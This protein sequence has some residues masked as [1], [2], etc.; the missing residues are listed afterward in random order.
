[1]VTGLR[2]IPS[3]MKRE[4]RGLE[5]LGSHVLAA[6]KGPF[7]AELPK[8]QCWSFRS[9]SD[10]GTSSRKSERDGCRTES[11]HPG[12]LGMKL[13]IGETAYKT[14]QHGSTNRDA[15]R[16]YAPGQ[17][18]PVF[19]P[20]P[21]APPEL[22]NVRN[23][24]PASA[25]FTQPQSTAA[26]AAVCCSTCRSLLQRQAQSA[27]ATAAVCCGACCSLLQRQPY[28]LC[29]YI[30]IYIYIYTYTYVYIYII[31]IIIIII[32]F[33]APASTKPAG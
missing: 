13:G 4:V 28:I 22:P 1:M 2:L 26:P 27:A 18:G 24:D 31:I 19:V 7:Q 8:R 20:A 9:G 3:H 30:Y 29:M 23:T 6:V 16:P 21:P 33:L 14:G 25:V 10:F 12:S 15:G 5:P 32:F 11:L 17:I